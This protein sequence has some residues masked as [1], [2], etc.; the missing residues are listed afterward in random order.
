MSQPYFGISIGSQPII[1]YNYGARNIDRVKETL[2]KVLTVNFIIGFVFN[3][4][5]V[6]FPKQL[7]SIFGSSND[8]LYLTFATDCCRIFMSVHVLNV[9]EMTTGI[10]VQ[11]LGSVKVATSVTFIRQ[12]VLYIPITIALTH[13]IG[14]YGALYASPIAGIICFIVVVFIF[15]AEYKKLDKN[16]FESHTIS[17]E[18]TTNNTLKDKII[19]T[20]NREYG[21]G[22]R[23]I[24][25][26]LADELGIKFYD[27][28]L[29]KLISEKEGFSEEF[30]E[31][32]EQKRKW[33]SSLNSE[34]N[35]E[36]K[37]FVAESKIIKEVAKNE[38]CV[39]IGRCADFV[40]EGEENLC[41][42]FIYSNNEGKINRA[43]KYYNMEE[44]TALK[45]INKINKERAKHYKY[46]T[47]K[48]WNDFSNYD[49]TFNSD[50]LGVEQ[51]AKVIKEIVTR[52]YK[53]HEE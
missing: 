15:G 18:L 42:I 44:K 6:L 37:L 21:S 46:Y 36:D 2:K 11:S 23:Y 1:G 27:K 14:L 35:E 40:L 34:Y 30:I 17:D 19:I 10:V 20:I 24:G 45:E 49:F 28:D 5:V 38:S 12:I 8:T 43:V 41:K 7:V 9:L 47:N 25:K 3:L 33:G 22:G 13:F 4:I 48:E 39:I 51:T 16:K 32:N 31:E 52:K 26:I 29:I 50:Y 53:E